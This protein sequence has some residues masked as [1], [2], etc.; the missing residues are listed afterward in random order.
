MG[1]RPARRAA[2]A[3]GVRWTACGSCSGGSPA[4]DARATPNTSPAQPDTPKAQRNSSIVARAANPAPCLP[5]C[6]AARGTPDTPPPGRL[7]ARR[8]PA[9]H[10]APPH[11][12]PGQSTHIA[13]ALQELSAWP[14]VGKPSSCGGSARRA[15]HLVRGSTDLFWRRR[16]VVRQGLTKPS[17]GGSNPTLSSKLP[18]VK[19]GP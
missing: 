9:W 5:R 6:A 2:R 3:K 18:A 8:A 13:T 11:T 12:P 1:R 17:L 10:P 4:S 15:I 16:Q 7:R 14:A 19:F